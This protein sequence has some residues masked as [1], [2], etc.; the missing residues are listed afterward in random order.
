MKTW[1]K[2]VLITLLVFVVLFV[3][4][5]NITPGHF[6][7]SCGCSIEYGQEPI[8]RVVMENGEVAEFTGEICPMVVCSNVIAIGTRFVLV[9]LSLLD[10]NK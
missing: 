9:P 4:W 2:T 6:R 5:M 8:E 10:F 3:G 1:F 7:S